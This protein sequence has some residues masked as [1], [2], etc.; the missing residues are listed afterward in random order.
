VSEIVPLTPVVNGVTT[1]GDTYC[2][3]PAGICIVIV[4]V[5]VTLVVMKPQPVLATKYSV[6]VS[7][8]LLVLRTENQA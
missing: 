2:V 5:G 8:T 4:S 7:G 6:N 3:W 1:P